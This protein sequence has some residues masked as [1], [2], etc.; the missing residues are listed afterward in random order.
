MLAK[1]EGPHNIRIKGVASAPTM[2]AMLEEAL[3]VM[4]EDKARAFLQSIPLRRAAQPEEIAAMVAMLVAD[5]AS[6][7]TGQ[8]SLS[9][10]ADPPAS[11]R[12]C[13]PVCVIAGRRVWSLLSP[14]LL[15]VCALRSLAQASDG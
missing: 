14:G 7:C 5:V 10:V 12:R 4:G 8:T 1:E 9:M 3:A 6:F 13:S 15:S 11:R 2:T